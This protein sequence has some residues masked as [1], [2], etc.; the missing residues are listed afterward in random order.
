MPRLGGPAGGSFNCLDWEFSVDEAARPFRAAVRKTGARGPYGVPPRTI[1]GAAPRP[2]LECA[3]PFRERPRRVFTDAHPHV[4]ECEVICRAVFSQTE[5]AKR[6]TDA[7][8]P[9]RRTDDDELLGSDHR[10]ESSSTLNP[11]QHLLFTQAQ[12]TFQPARP[13]S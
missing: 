9:E 7:P 6:E 5:S 13:R 1:Y 10:F 8:R 12:P 4:R 2:A 11:Q 3:G